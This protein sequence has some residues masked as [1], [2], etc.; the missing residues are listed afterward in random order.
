MGY[1]LPKTNPVGDEPGSVEEFLEQAAVM[2][3]LYFDHPDNWNGD[4]ND[5]DRHHKKTKATWHDWTDEQ[6][7]KYYNHD[8][9]VRSDFPL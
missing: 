9:H 1:T 8:P 6:K 3:T 2:L 4:A 5:L 7:V